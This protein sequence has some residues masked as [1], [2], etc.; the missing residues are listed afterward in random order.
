MGRWRPRGSG[1]GRRW[2]PPAAGPS[3]ARGRPRSLAARAGS[4]AVVLDLDE[5]VLVAEDLLIPG[6]SFSASARLSCRMWSENS[7]RDAAREADQGPRCGARGSPCRSSAC[8]RTL[9][10]TTS[11]RAASGCGSPR[12]C[13]PAA[14][15]G[16]TSPCPSP[17]AGPLGPPA[18][19]DVRL[20]A[21]D[22][23]DPRRLRLAEELD[24]AVEVAVV[25]QRQRR[26]SPAP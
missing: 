23:L 17:P 10:G 26:S 8:S 24:R 21:D 6:A 2:S 13:G 4:H 5:E 18:R 3:A 20:D 7:D 15:G 25:G 1:S 16:T 22:R 9:P 11:T 19:R 12:R 14:S